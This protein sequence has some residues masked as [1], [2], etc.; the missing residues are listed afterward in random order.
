MSSFF[1]QLEAQLRA[2]ARSRT[3]TDPDPDP[4]A[5]PAR[6]SRWSW[7][8]AGLRGAPV[9]VAVGT[10][11]V[12]VVAA[13]VFL[14]RG[15]GP[16][17]PTPASHPAP[18]AGWTP[19]ASLIAAWAHAPRQELRYL[20]QAENAALRAPACRGSEQGPQALPNI[21]GTPSRSLLSQLAILRRPATAADR[22]PASSL[23]GI[24]GM[25][26]G[27]ARLALRT[28]GASYYLVPAKSDPRAGQPGPAC[29]AARR[30]ALHRLLPGIPASMRAGA[31]K[32]QADQIAAEQSMFSRPAQD[33]VCFVVVGHNYGSTS[34]GETAAQ[35]RNGQLPQASGSGSGSG[36]FTQAGIV[37]DGV[38][39][40][41]VT[42]ATPGHHHVTM[43]AL[44]H[45]NVYVMSAPP[46]GAVSAM[47]WRAADGRVVKVV[48]GHTGANV[49]RLCRQRRSPKCIA[50]LALAYA[51]SGS[52]S[53]YGY[54]SSAS[55]ASA[56][57][58]ASASAS[59]TATVSSSGSAP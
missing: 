36:Q 54:G 28:G 7:L 4:T 40:V 24:G 48:S 35:L 38:A 31:L 5:A 41:A 39:T 2:A 37:P 59:G 46:N 9:A 20:N 12:I 30:A 11:V 23:Q 17:S 52:G 57:G 44:T 6:R 8:R 15:K 29:L 25:Y 43:T 21:H 14:G 13:L 22:V 27:A 45:D 47:T 55:S 51:Q 56:S 34:C 58:S 3:G 42:W 53:S 26:I 10:T 19:Y 33:M 16:A 49:T 18:S 50:A 32:L 1:D